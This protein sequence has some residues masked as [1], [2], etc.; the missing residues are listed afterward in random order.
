MKRQRF[1]I[2]KRGKLETS[3]LNPFFI[4]KVVFPTFNIVS[5]PTIRTSEVKSHSFDAIDA[6]DRTARQQIMNQEDDAVFQALD[7]L[8]KK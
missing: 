8:G 2:N 7:N 4:R 1:I 5:N 6:I 3:F